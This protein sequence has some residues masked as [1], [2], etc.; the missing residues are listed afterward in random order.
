MALRSVLTITLLTIMFSGCSG[1]SDTKVQDETAETPP[2]PTQPPV[3]SSSP[4]NST[5]PYAQF[6]F[7]SSAE[8]S[9]ECQLDSNSIYPCTSPVNVLLQNVGEH[10]LSVWAIDAN[11]LKSEENT[12]F[13]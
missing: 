11:G 13:W 2:A 12:H 7:T 8:V 1:G 5:Q 9:Y 3:F 4:S 6:S 10:Q